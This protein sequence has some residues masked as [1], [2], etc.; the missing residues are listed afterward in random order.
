MMDHMTCLSQSEAGMVLLLLY[1]V[2]H[3]KLKTSLLKPQHQ[4][5]HSFFT[6]VQHGLVSTFGCTWGGGGALII[7]IIIYEGISV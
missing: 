2:K 6:E 7:I 3:N 4:N 1:A 5:E